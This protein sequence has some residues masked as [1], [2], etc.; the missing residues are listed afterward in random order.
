MTSLFVQ[1]LTKV[2]YANRSLV[3]VGL[4]P[5]PKHM[6]VQDVLQFNRAIVD[7]THDLVCAYKPNLAFYEGLG[8][9]GLKALESTLAHIRTQ[10]PQVV[11]I[12]DAKRGDIGNTSIAYA[13]ALFEVWGFDA[14]TISPYLGGDSLEPFLVYRDKGS[15]LLCRTSNAGARDIQELVL[16]ANDEPLYVHVARKAK[17]WNKNGNVCLVVGATAPDE[18]KR[19]RLICADMPILIP[20]IGA[21]AGDLAA[22]VC[23]GVDANGRLAVINSSRGIIYASRGPD[24]ATAARRATESL[25]D[26]I[27]KVLEQ[28]GKGWS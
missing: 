13:R 1:R 3:C 21:Q 15:F 14:A 28:E 23:N 4:D 24:Y 10:A 7:A 27:N 2:S 12:A 9:A 22:G 11:V 17:E 18:M 5:D 25:R 6:P 8:M 26:A 19:V 16:K 20:G